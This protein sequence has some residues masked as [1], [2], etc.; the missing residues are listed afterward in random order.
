MKTTCAL[1]TDSIMVA[2]G[3]PRALG[4]NTLEC[5]SF[6]PVKPEISSSSKIG[7][8]G[9]R[10]NA[11]GA[12]PNAGGPRPN[13]GG[14]RSNSGGVRIGAGRARR[15]DVPVVAVDNAGLRWYAVETDL[16][17]EYDVYAAIA[18]LG[19]RCHLPR[20][21]DYS[22]KPKRN[23]RLPI[24]A[25]LIAGFVL[26]EFDRAAP[27]WRRIASLPNVKGL[28]GPTSEMPTPARVGE[29][30]RLIALGRAGDG[31]IDDDAT[32]FPTGRVREGQTVK[33]EE[34]AFASFAGICQWSD[35]KRLRILT[36][37][38]GHAA[39]VELRHDQ[40]SLI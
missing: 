22:R 24:I 23:A 31:V 18:N 21:V 9:A 11:G 28:L 32:P 13:S 2:S 20:F 39:T 33:I 4:E 12:R 26:V 7:W 5:G 29:V 16:R 40:V 37:I 3:S 35:K 14:A 1:E 27:G 10:R 15:A 25:L 6:D 30:E 38:F 19:F 34:G 36:E 17:S 8:G